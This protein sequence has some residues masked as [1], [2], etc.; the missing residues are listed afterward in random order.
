[1]RGMRGLGFTGGG[2][3]GGVSV[4]LETALGS[5][6]GGGRAHEEAR[7]SEMGGTPE[8]GCGLYLGWGVKRIIGGVVKFSTSG[9]LLF[10]PKCYNKFFRSFSSI[11]PVYGF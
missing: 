7:Q 1:M 5:Q 3:K 6:L 10:S 4:G 2:G 9:Y 11:D 8:I